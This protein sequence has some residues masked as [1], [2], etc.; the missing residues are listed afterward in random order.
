MSTPNADTAREVEITGHDL[1]LH[2]PTPSAPLWSRHPRF[3]L[4]PH[5]PSFFKKI[6]FGLAALEGVVA[7][8]NGEAAVQA[9]QRGARQKQKSLRRKL[10]PD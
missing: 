9:S 10:R 2:C 6:S 5:N 1:P 4:V 7:Q 3:I 8:L